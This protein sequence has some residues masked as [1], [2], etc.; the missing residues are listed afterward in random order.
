MMFFKFIWFFLGY[1]LLLLNLE[2][3]LFGLWCLVNLFDIV[4]VYDV[5]F[6][7]LVLLGV[8]CYLVY[9]FL[10]GFLVFN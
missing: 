8:W 1:V 2:G 3:I 7:Y 5:Y 4:G 9:W 6:I 10:K